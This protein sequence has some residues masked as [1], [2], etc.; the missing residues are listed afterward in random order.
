MSA[1]TVARMRSRWSGGKGRRVSGPAADDPDGALEF[2]PVGVDG[3]FGGGPADQGADRAVG[4]Q[5]ANSGATSEC[6][7][8][9][10]QCRPIRDLRARSTR[11]LQRVLPET[12]GF[13]PSPK[14]LKDLAHYSREAPCDCSACP[15]SSLRLP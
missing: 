14:H 9:L 15:L 5:V 12:I 13:I 2:D 6:Y 10:R 4:E 7:G 3:G 1:M 8:H 11:T